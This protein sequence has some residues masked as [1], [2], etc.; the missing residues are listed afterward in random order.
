LPAS[1]SSAGG[2]AAVSRP[3]VVSLFV[4]SGLLSVVS[5]YTTWQGMALYL[6]P[7][8]SVLA[9]LG[10]QS[11]L[12]LV[13]WLVG[14]T[15]TRQALL[16]V[17][18]AVTAVVSIA[19]SYVSLYTW[20][21]ARER[22][23]AVQRRLYDTLAEAGGRSREL[24][25]AAVAEGQK[26]ALALEEMAA[27]EK[28]HGYV[29][30]SGDA[31]PWLTRVREAVAEEARSFAS[32]YP[33]GAGAGLRYTA[34]DRHAR[35]ARQTV[36]QIQQSQRGFADLLASRKPLEPTETQL[37]TFRQVYDAVPWNEVRDTL[38]AGPLELPAVPSYSDFVDHSAT[39][40]EDLLLAFEELLSAPTSRHATAFTLA[41]FIDVV[42]FLLAW[43]SGPFFLGLPEE[44]WLAAG[45]AVD[46]KDIPV[47]VRDLVCKLRPG[48]QATTCLD[49][50]TLSAGEQQ[51][52]LVMAAKGLA[53]SVEKEERQLYLIDPGVHE[54]LI[55]VLADR[56]LPLRAAPVLSR[57]AGC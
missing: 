48:P 44:R 45:A 26:H 18:Y 23:A 19:F 35:I 13:A 20:F 16:I 39:S 21:S 57:G 40:Q 56:P 32:S 30:R 12:V 9:S 8:F 15:R 1:S 29:S 53:A 51:L 36:A 33:E 10:I 41:A 14:I 38:H 27:A 34:F 4:A 24:L 49:S 25:T 47:F 52:C 11:A 6:S 50:R 2:S 7:W 55:E 43:A 5:W 37:R 31:D 3:L 28:A 46:A 17:V 42:V 54:R 22:P